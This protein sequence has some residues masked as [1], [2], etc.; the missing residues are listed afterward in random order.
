MG[1]MG[2]LSMILS[3][4]AMITAL[5]AVWFTSETIKKANSANKQFFESNVK[6]I[7]KTMEDLAT[8]SVQITGKIETLENAEKKVD[9]STLMGRLQDVES[10]LGEMRTNMETLEK[11]VPGSPKQMQF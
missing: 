8:S 2:I 10:A 6:N 3:V 5:A 11:L 1:T 4:F 9:P 7:A